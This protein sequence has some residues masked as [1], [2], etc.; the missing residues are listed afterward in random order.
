MKR[1]IT[2]WLVA[3]SFAAA[4][5]PA[6]LETGRYE[7]TAF[8]TTAGKGGK[9]VLEIVT[10][11][12]DKVQA[13][14]AASEG[15]IGE[16]WLTGKLAGGRLELAGDLLGWHMT[17]SAGARSDGI[18]GTYQL[19]GKGVQQGRFEVTRRGPASPVLAAGEP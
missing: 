18:A 4:A 16:G 11:D 13:R 15:L 6:A 17:L 3:V 1:A 12:G 9:L 2:T 5:A 7:G 10:V 14:F 19:E 8:N